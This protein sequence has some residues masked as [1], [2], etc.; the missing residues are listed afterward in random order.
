[1]ALKNLSPLFRKKTLL[2]THSGCDVDSLASA[3]AIHLSLK[4]KS[5]T[6]I[7]V[8]DHMNSSA[9]ALAK[10]LSIP[11]TL[12]PSLDSFDC[13][14]CLDFNNSSMLGSMQGQFL[15][16][17]GEKFLIDHHAHEKTRIAPQKNS[18]SDKNAIS[19]TEIVHDLLL[20]TRVKIPRSALLCIGAGII[21][22]SASFLIADHETFSIMAEVLRKASVPYSE[23]VSL[24]SVGKD[25][26][27]KVACLKA[28]KRCR[29][30]KSGDS[31]IAISDVGA[32]EADAAS[33]LVRIGADA[34][35]CGYAEK[36]AV[37]VSGRVNNQWLR[38]NSFDLARDV[39]NRLESFFEGEGGGHA[40]AAGFNGPGDSVE[41]PLMKCAELV[42]EFLAKK[43]GLIGG[44]KEY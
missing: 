10:K 15:S 30:F 29:I 23:I 5:K 36:G 44:M 8:P 27:E 3:A 12:N 34:A 16:F 31:I 7:G 24:F 41:K 14:V 13:I 37:R 20:A 35:F 6:S 4:S 25:F 1:M 2:L 32:F 38:S 33:A 40:G 21:T 39:F 43:T 18:R 19:T 11:F 42:H 22:D 28:A 17:K 9:S 26:S